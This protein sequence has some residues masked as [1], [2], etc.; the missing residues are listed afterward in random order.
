M[1]LS[2]LLSLVAPVL[3]VTAILISPTMLRG[4]TGGN[5]GEIVGQVLDF[6]SATIS[7][8]EVTVRNTAT[9]FTR[10]TTTDDMGRYAVSLLPL[11]PYEVTIKAPGFN[12]AVR[13]TSVGLGNSVTADFNLA[14]GSNQ[15]VV[16]IKAEP[17]LKDATLPDSK[18]VLSDLQIQNLPSDGGRLQ[19]LIWLI[20]G[21]QLE[22]E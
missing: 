12:I 9:N 5:T 10:T 3:A 4:Q 22:P 13:E 8:A 7:G 15:Q 16:Q 14:V 18:S 6:S 20:A 19:N 17:A 11:G 1:K 21:G 2:R